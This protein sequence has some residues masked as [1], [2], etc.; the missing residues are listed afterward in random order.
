MSMRFLIFCVPQQVEERIDQA[1]KVQQVSS[2]LS[3]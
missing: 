1:R 2:N 3:K